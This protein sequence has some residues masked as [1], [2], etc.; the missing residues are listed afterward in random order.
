MRGKLGMFVLG[1]VVA[2]ALMSATFVWRVYRQERA[3]WEEFQA[4]HGKAR[5]KEMEGLDRRAP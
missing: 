3:R 4:A 1:C 5:A 2:A